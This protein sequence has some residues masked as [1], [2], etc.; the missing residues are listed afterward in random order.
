MIRRP[1]VELDTSRHHGVVLRR[2]VH[3]I[4]GS[5]TKC[6]TWILREKYPTQM[7]T[8]GVQIGLV[9]A[10]GYTRTRWGARRCLLRAADRDPAR[11]PW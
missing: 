2:V 1:V 6:W 9:I 4:D 11:N 8:S 10:C 7:T 3:E 5:V